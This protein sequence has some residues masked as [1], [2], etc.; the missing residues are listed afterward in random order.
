MTSR[1]P[2]M[3]TDP[4][5]IVYVIDDDRDVRESIRFML[6]TDGIT[7]HAFAGGQEFMDAQPDLAPGCL[8]LDVRMPRMG[9]L[10]VLAA[11]SE[12]GCG[13]PVVVM[14]GHGEGDL[15]TRAINLGARDFIEK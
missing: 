11:L 14:T 8:L 13:W 9:G 6:Q 2:E 7:S 15:G 12:R 3:P 4:A 1:E 5:P 10:E